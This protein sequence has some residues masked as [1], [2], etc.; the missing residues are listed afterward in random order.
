MPKWNIYSIW[1]ITRVQQFE[2]QTR[3]S[4]KKAVPESTIR[5]SGGSIQPATKSSQVKIMA[6]E[7]DKLKKIIKE[8]SNKPVL[9]YAEL[10]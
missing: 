9:C 5:V 4:H 3:G 1:E 7:I 2:L 8:W 6:E 10:K